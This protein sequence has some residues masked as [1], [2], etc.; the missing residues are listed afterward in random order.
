MLKMSEHC[1]KQSLQF[2]VGDITRSS[3]TLKTM[4]R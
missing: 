3:M 4:V 2:I 1:E